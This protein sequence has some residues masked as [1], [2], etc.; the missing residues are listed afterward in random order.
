M[1]VVITSGG[2]GILYLGDAVLHEL[3]LEHPDW[4]SPIDLIPSLTISTRRKLLER[5]VREGSAVIAFHMSRA[6]PLVRA[7][8][9]Y[10]LGTSE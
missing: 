3:N 5:A 1:A 6:G 9:S 10:R 7:G 8:D 2:T 4:V